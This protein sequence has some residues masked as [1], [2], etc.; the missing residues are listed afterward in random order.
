[1]QWAALLIA[2]A[3]LAVA[4]WTLHLERRNDARATERH[5]VHWT[6][7]RD[8]SGWQV[9]NDGTDEAREVRLVVTIYDARCVLELDRVEAGQAIPV[10]VDEPGRG[11]LDP[12]IPPRAAFHARWTTPAGSHREQ[13]G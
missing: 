1:M 3:A 9:T 6:I 12:V 13:S 2:V 4:G 7:G 10:E 11:P 8:A 5:D